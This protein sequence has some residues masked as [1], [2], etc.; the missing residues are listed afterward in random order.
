MAML[1]GGFAGKAEEIFG[2]GACKKEAAPVP[3]A[4][5][6]KPAADLIGLMLKAE[7]AQPKPTARNPIYANFGK[8]TKGSGASRGGH[9]ARAAT[10][11]SEH[12]SPASPQVT[13]CL[14]EANRLCLH[15]V[16]CHPPFLQKLADL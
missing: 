11:N 2:E 14:K 3:N 5:T 10:A 9:K 12:G 6:S 16:E 15:L 13:A 1:S 4:A 8:K 7:R